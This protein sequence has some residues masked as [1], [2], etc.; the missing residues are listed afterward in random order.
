MNYPDV[1]ESTSASSSGSGDETG[2]DDGSSGAAAETSTGGAATTTGGEATSVG[3]SSGPVWEDSAG[4]PAP[5][6]VSLS[7]TPSPVQER[8]PLVITAVTAH[9]TEVAL[10]LD[11]EALGVFAPQA[12]VVVHEVPIACDGQD[13][14]H[15]IAAVARSA[16]GEAPAFLPFT[17]DLPPGG[18]DVEVPWLDQDAAAFSGAF[19]LARDG[20]RVVTLGLL[21]SGDGWR[22]VLREHGSHGALLG[23]RAL[24]DWTAREDLL[25]A[26]IGGIGMGAAFGADGQL[27]VAANLTLADESVVR[28]YL[29]GLS[30]QG[31]TIFPEVLLAQGEVIE[32]IFARDGVVVAVGHKQVAGGRT[33]AAMWAFNTTTGKPVWAPVLVEAPQDDGMQSPPLSARFQAVTFTNDGNLLAAGSLQD[34]VSLIEV[35]WRALFVRVSPNGLKLGEP[36]V[37]D[38]PGFYEQTMALAVAPF[39]G[40]DGFCWTGHSRGDVFDPEVMVAEC[41]GE[42]HMQRISADWHNS[43]GLAIAYTPVT[44]RVIVGGYRSGTSGNGW[45]MS[46]ADSFAPLESPH[47]WKYEY[48]S[49]AGGFDE[50]TALACQTYECDVLLV[51]DLFGASRVRL[52]RVNQ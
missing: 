36:E 6:W 32:G 16:V 9:A 21:D 24:A 42:T 7:A 33:V 4:E 34:G 2:A 40:P 35:T 27:F 31:E 26:A 49:P 19:A 1:T 3:E 13:G 15:Q 22:L 11:G 10:T 23:K 43:A 14:P 5:A 52:A 46:F 38:D 29:A 37:F 30:P 44:G 18:Q 25:T 12:G 45:V 48:D 41:R 28:G 51:S 39:T 17:V 20:E 47:G 50:V 8:G